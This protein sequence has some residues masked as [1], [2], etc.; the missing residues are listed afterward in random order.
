MTIDTIIQYLH[1]YGYYLIFLSLFFGIVG[2]PAP[3][4]SLLVFIGMASVANDLS[5]GFSMICAFI[6]TVVG[7]ITAYIVG[8][9]IGYGIVRKFGH[10]VGLTEERWTTVQKKYK[11]NIH[12]TIVFGFY[13]PGVRQINPYFAGAARVCFLRYIIY[14]FIGSAIWTVPYILA[15]YV[16]GSKM[17]LPPQYVSYFGLLLFAL[18][19]ISIAFKFLQKKLYNR[20]GAKSV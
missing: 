14:S 12:R 16:V 9:M 11:K 10:L 13:L 5:L 4:E 17:N 18:F 19:I 20:R 2:I 6:G 1:T 3:E 15:G 8:K 7:M